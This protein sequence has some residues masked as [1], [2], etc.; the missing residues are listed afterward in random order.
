MKNISIDSVGN[1]ALNVFDRLR[2]L[3]YTYILDKYSRKFMFNAINLFGMLVCL[4]LFSLTDTGTNVMTLVYMFLPG[5]KELVGMA[6][7]EMGSGDVTALSVKICI[8]IFSAISCVMGAYIFI[9]QMQ[10]PN[11]HDEE[12]DGPAEI[13]DSSTRMSIFSGCLSGLGYLSMALKHLK[14]NMTIAEYIML[15][16]YIVIAIVLAAIIPYGQWKLAKHIRLQNE[17]MISNVNSKTDTSISLA[18]NNETDRNRKN[19][20]G[21]TLEERREMENNKLLALKER[22]RQKV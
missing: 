19:D 21:L 11:Y 15:A 6:N 14:P 16:V 8:Y 13:H 18:I 9:A 4:M 3:G 20:V 17:E 1:T 10:I 22:M 2:N 7:P 12:S 5:V